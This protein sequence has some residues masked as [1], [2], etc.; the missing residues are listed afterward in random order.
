[1]WLAGGGVRGGDEEMRYRWRCAVGVVYGMVFIVRGGTRRGEG[2]EVGM[3]EWLEGRSG[4]TVELT[5][6]G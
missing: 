3:W 4:V 2:R 5:V 1:M 6:D